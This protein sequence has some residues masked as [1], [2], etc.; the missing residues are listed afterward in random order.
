MSDFM[1]S[2]NTRRVSIMGRTQGFFRVG[3]LGEGVLGTGGLFND[4]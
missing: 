2:L 3:L 4:A 1:E